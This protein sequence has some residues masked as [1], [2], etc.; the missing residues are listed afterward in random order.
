LASGHHPT[1]RNGDPHRRLEGMDSRYARVTMVGARV[2]RLRHPRA[3]G[4]H[5][6]QLRRHGLPMR[7]SD[8]GE[9]ESD[10][11]ARRTGEAREWRGP[12]IRA[13]R[14]STSQTRRYGL[15][16]RESDDGGCESDD[17]EWESDEGARRTGE[18][19]GQRGPV[20]LA[21][22]GST[23][24]SFEDMDSRYARVTME[25]ARVTVESLT[26]L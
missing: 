8:D 17:G 11:G 18:A 2:T 5:K 22:R 19:R 26:Q 7:K 14:G 4:I 25:G 10:E 15:P 12:V 1:S 3:A 6:P 21:Q 9:W 20:I 16:L 13:Q 24:R 23:N